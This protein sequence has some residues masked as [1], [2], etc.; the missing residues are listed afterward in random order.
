MSDPLT[1]PKP[2]RDSCR[3]V[4]RFSVAD[5]NATYVGRFSRYHAHLTGGQLWLSRQLSIPVRTIRAKEIIRRGWL[6][7]RHALRIVFENPTT[8]EQ[9]AAHLCDI[10]FLGFYHLRNLEKL[11]AAL[12]E[13][14]RETAGGEAPAVV[15][16][17]P[18]TSKTTLGAVLLQSVRNLFKSTDAFRIELYQDAAK[19]IGVRLE[20]PF[21]S[22]DEVR[23]KLALAAKERGNEQLADSVDAIKGR[24]ILGSRICALWVIAWAVLVPVAVLAVWLVPRPPEEWTALTIAITA[25][26][27]L[28]GFWGCRGRTTRCVCP[29]RT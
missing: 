9:D 3:Y 27:C 1:M 26:I 22:A 29:Q 19:S 23:L 14:L 15:A 12:D 10:D 6:I 24:L 18:P 11:S 17:M 8:R 28:V 2:P 13:V 25:G 4:K 16:E 7:K 21:V 20:G 5:E